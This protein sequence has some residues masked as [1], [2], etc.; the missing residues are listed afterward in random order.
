MAILR[1]TAKLLK[2]LGV[3]P[4]S[5][6]DQPPDLFGWHCN[7]L[8]LNRRKYV[9]FTNDQT[10]YSF[11]IRWSKAPQSPDFLE[12][13]RLGLFKSLMNE[14]IA[15]PQIEYFLSKH[16]HLTVTKTNNRS[17]LGSM[18]DL[19]L[20]VKYRAYE[21]GELTDARLSG[22]NRELNDI[23]MG[24]IKYNLSNVELKRRLADTH[25]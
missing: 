5:L 10:L 4:E 23:P 7:L 24:A 12:R 1:C 14:R 8:R 22:I 17:V 9:L 13:F 3:K 18:N 16:K 15:E 20:Q 21:Y 19:T 6:A 25:E 2:E 11:L